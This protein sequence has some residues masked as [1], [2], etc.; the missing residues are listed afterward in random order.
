MNVRS[1]PGS[2]RRSGAAVVEMAFVLPVLVMFIFGIF[3]YGRFVF[4]YTTATNAARD[5]ARY[6]VVHTQDKVKADVVTVVTNKMG[7]LDK[8]IVGYAVD[9]FYADPGASGLGATPP[10]L[11]KNPSFSGAEDWK[12]APFPDK[13]AVQIT[14]DYYPTMAWIVK[15]PVKYTLKISSM[16]TSEN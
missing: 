14:G 4:T 2:R 7:R 11:Q 9:V 13:I 16:M 1:A 12:N 6:A 15:A 8:Q 3:E 5:G 10:V